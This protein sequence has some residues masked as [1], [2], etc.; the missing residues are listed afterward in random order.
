LAPDGQHQNSVDLVDVMVKGDIA[1]RFPPNNEF[2]LSVSDRSANQRILP[3]HFD[4]LNYLVDTAGN[5]RWC[6]LKL[7]S[8]QSI[9]VLQNFRSQLDARHFKP[10]WS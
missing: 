3:E 5:F 9:E 8:K 1:A 10:V 4:R 2:P 6:V 7:V